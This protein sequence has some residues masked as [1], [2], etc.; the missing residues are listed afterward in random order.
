MA[1][2]S[3]AYER[4]NLFSTQAGQGAYYSAEGQLSF[5]YFF[6]TNTARGLD[7]RSA[8]LNTRRTLS[9]ATR[10]NQ[11]RSSYQ[12]ALLDDNGDGVWDSHSD[13]SLAK[14]TYLGLNAATATTFPVVFAH[15]GDMSINAQAQPTVS[16]NARVDLPPHLLQKVW[17][18]VNAPGHDVDTMVSITQLPEVELVY[19]AANRMYEGATNLLTQPGEYTLTYYAQSTQGNISEPISATVQVA[20]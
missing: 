1:S 6:W 10:G 11:G 16:I 15:Q 14:V 9:T 7:V 3:D 13:G 17:V 5:S 18:L 4:V 12:R 8:F 2:P 19:N 20:Q